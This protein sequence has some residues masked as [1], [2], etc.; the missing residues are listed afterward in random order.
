MWLLNIWRKGQEMLYSYYKTMCFLTLSKSLRECR[1]MIVHTWRTFHRSKTGNKAWLHSV[2]KCGTIQRIEDFRLPNQCCQNWPQCD[3]VFWLG[4][5]SK[6]LERSMSYGQI[7]CRTRTTRQ[8]GSLAPGSAVCIAWSSVADLNVV[9]NR[10][11][12][13][14]M[15]WQWTDIC[16]RIPWNAVT[17]MRFG[18]VWMSF[19]RNVWE[20]VNN[21]PVPWNTPTGSR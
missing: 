11:Q 15:D 18:Y 17:S 20:T 12:N 8:S 14:K 19:I 21:S 13:P 7:S 1:I 9:E 3:Q 2:V 10:V 4:R 16:H 6:F 5:S